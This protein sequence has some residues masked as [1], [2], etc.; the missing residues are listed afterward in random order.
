LTVLT[1]PVWQTKGIIVSDDIGLNEVVEQTPLAALV[2][3]FLAQP[4]AQNHDEAYEALGS[5]EEAIL[6]AAKAQATPGKRVSPQTRIVQQK[7]EVSLAALST[8]KEAIAA[9]TNYDDLLSIV[10]KKLRGIEG[11]GNMYI[12]STARR[13]GVYMRLHPQRVYLNS[14][15]TR[16]GARALKLAYTKPYVNMVSLPREL[17]KLQPRQ[18]EDFL[19]LYKTRLVELGQ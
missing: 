3:D 7:L 4:E 2:E 11:L 5:L 15:G 19:N 13:I 6:F 1:H 10:E 18:V 9:C 8:A 12:H 17:R 14:G 16:E